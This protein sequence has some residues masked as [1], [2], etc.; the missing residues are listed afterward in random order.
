MSGFFRQAKTIVYC[1][2]LIFY[3]ATPQITHPADDAAF[4]YPAEWET[5]G[6]LWV[7]FRTTHE[8]A[9]YEPVLNRMLAALAGHVHLNLLVESAENLLPPKRYFSSIGLR[10]NDFTVVN[11]KTPYFWLRDTGPIFLRNRAGKI[12]ILGVPFTRYRDLADPQGQLAAANHQKYIDKIAQSLGIEIIPT[13]IVLEGGAFDVN[14]A[15]VVLLSSTIRDR[16]PQWSKKVLERK[17]LQA[18]GQ[19][20]AIWL[21]QGIAEDPYGFSKITGHIWGRGTGGHLDQFVRFVNGHTVLLAWVS[22]QE[23][24]N[25]VLA[26]INFQRMNENYIILKNSTDL[27]GKKMT[28]IKVPFPPPD[29]YDYIITRETEPLYR[30]RGIPLHAGDKIQVVAA[31]SYLNFIITNDLILLP[32]YEGIA[33]NNRRTG[34]DV[35]MLKIME[36]FFPHRKIV[37]VNPLRLNRHGGGMHCLVQQQP[38]AFP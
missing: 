29:I 11:T 14:G 7:G 8:G 15:G 33:V 6:N 30:Q 24:K 34:K 27:K 22:E 28:I 23:R 1:F 5:L 36:K 10:D 13:D 16:N 18:L 17:I 20:K 19:H 2:C 35:T 37:Q 25:S 31:A 32:G 9:N 12:K 4:Y 21:K 26:K 3:L 38:R